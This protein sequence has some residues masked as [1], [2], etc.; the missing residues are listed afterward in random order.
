MATQQRISQYATANTIAG[1]I[2]AAINKQYGIYDAEKAK[3][4]DYLQ[5]VPDSI[6]QSDLLAEIQEIGTLSGLTPASIDIDVKQ[7]NRSQAAASPTA[8]ALRSVP[9]K[10]SL[11]GDY[12]GIRQFLNLVEH[13][14][15]ILDGSEMTISPGAATDK[16]AASPYKIQFTFQT[17]A[18]K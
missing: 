15:P 3:A 17:Y 6:S 16:K 10:I 4:H 2:K 12:P 8:P 5:A 7:A 14:L 13:N 1:Q 18:L 11:S 9:V